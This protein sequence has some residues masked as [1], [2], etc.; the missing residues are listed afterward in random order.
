[1]DPQIPA[2]CEHSSLKLT[3]RQRQTVE[4]VSRQFSNSSVKSRY[5]TPGR[6]Y[7]EIE[8]SYEEKLTLLEVIQ[9]FKAQG[10]KDV[11]NE[12]DQNG[13]TSEPGSEIDRE[14]GLIRK[15]SR[16]TL[17]HNHEELRVGLYDK[18]SGRN[19]LNSS[20]ENPGRLYVTEEDV[21]IITRIAEFNHVEPAQIQGNKNSNYS[22]GE[23][24]IS[25][26]G[27]TCISDNR[28]LPYN[29]FL[30]DK[31][32]LSHE[33]IELK[34]VT[35]KEMERVRVVQLEPLNSSSPEIGND[36]L[37]FRSDN[38]SSSLS[39]DTGARVTYIGSEVVNIDFAKP[40]PKAVHVK[41]ETG[42]GKVS[43]LTSGS[44]HRKTNTPSPLER[45]RKAAEK[46]KEATKGIRPQKIPE[47]DFAIWKDRGN[48]GWFVLLATVGGILAFFGD[49][50]LD[51][52]VAADHFE[53]KDFWWCGLT[54]FLVFFPSLVVNLISFFWYAEDEEVTGREPETGWR[55]IYLIH[56]CQLGLAER[57]DH[58]SEARAPMIMI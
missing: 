2:D 39:S 26:I 18:R 14:D 42:E 25:H 52:K 40:E 34:T 10:K 8:A 23:C 44:Q 4:K 51:L 58:E 33:G 17:S 3:E 28:I 22:I 49:I 37:T 31:N 55:K 48:C 57:Y 16:T 54:A 20:F 7:V 50:A 15:S 1:M 29:G 38:D 53:N 56:F 24:D 36:N 32:G 12:V 13:D 43:V 5:V 9:V 27:E 45:F 30:S 11:N 21:E 6:F 41:Q 46:V 19:S 35:G 47:E